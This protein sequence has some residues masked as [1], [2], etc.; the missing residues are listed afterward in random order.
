MTSTAGWAAAAERQLGSS[1]IVTPDGLLDPDAARRAGTAPHLGRGGE[2]TWK[3]WIPL[4]AKTLAKDI[5]QYQR[6]RRFLVTPD[7]PWSG[8]SIDF[9]WQRHELF[10]RA[11][12]DLAQHLGAPLVMFVPATTVWEARQ[13][14]VTRPGWGRLLET[15]GERPAL[16]AARVVACGSDDVADQVVRIGVPRERVV[17]TPTGVDLELFNPA[18]DGAAVRRQHGLEGRFVVGWT[19]SF[20]RFHALDQVVDAM[21]E[22]DDATLLMVGDG[23]ERPHVEARARARGVRAVFTGTVPHH[24]LPGHLAA[25]DTAVVAAEPGT[26]FHYSPLKL[27]EYLAAGLPVVAPAVSGLAGR[28]THDGDALLVP[29]G[30]PAAIAHAVARLRDE[31]ATRHRIGVAARSSAVDRWGWDHQVRRVMAA[32]DG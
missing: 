17:V 3:G 2:A 28:L 18:A 10:H 16:T 11:G 1:W 31:P 5:R 6:A 26:S 14:G 29:A 21:A 25:M 7:G 22:I 32:L 12:V 9:V 24:E 27:A 15:V 13:W 20:R 4:P 8:T 23:P 30:D 19:G